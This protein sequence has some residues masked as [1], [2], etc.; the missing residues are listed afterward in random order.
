MLDLSQLSAADAETLELR[1]A[2]LPDMPVQMRAD[3][4]PLLRGNLEHMAD[5]GA[6]C[7]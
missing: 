3:L 2:A 5:P 7:Q 4:L 1:L 6:D